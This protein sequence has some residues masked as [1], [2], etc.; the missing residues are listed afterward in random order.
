[1]DAFRRVGKDRRGFAVVYIALMLV[2]LVA[3]VSLAVDMGYMYVAKGQ[4]QNAADAGA[5]AGAA[6]N[7]KDP[8]SVRQK[9]KQFA[10]TNKAAGD[11]VTITDG[12]VTIGN[13]NSTLTPQ[14]LASRNPSNAVRVVARRTEAGASAAE[15]GRVHTFFGRIF[16]L[17]QG[18]GEGWSEMTVSA[19]AI[20]SRPPRPTIPITLCQTA[21]TATTPA[22]FYFRQTGSGAPPAEYTIGWTVFLFDSQRMDSQDVIDYIHGVLN[23]PDVCNAAMYTTNGANMNLVKEVQ[24]EFI[25][26][27]AA[28]G[29]PYWEVIVPVVDSAV[30]GGVTVPSCPPGDQPIPYPLTRYAIARITA[31]DLAPEPG[32]TFSLLQCYPCGDP[33]LV[34]GSAV[35]VK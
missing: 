12:D 13:W 14:F 1:M 27:K 5:L 20:A 19:E 28:S 9:A 4:L 31:V 33:A 2:V 7:L 3:F 8:T 35:L 30:V 34:G 16:G 26:Q 18:G 10:A 21:C 22:K 17:L 25:A 29:L 11:A 23:P 32:L 15:Q 24:D 6:V